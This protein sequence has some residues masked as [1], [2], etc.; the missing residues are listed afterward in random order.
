MSTWTATIISLT[1]TGT[2]TEV[3]VVLFDGGSNKFQQSY[4][5]DGTL[6]SLAPL[7]RQTTA[8][9]DHKAQ[10]SDLVVGALIDLTPP[11][12]VTP[13]PPDPLVVQF[14]IDLQALQQEVR[15]LALGL[16]TGADVTALRAKVQSDL[17]KTPSLGS[18]L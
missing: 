8:Q 9:Q 16:T 14:L 2:G 4:Q 17:G 11:V 7:V 10:K 3:G 12:V 5:T 6:A 13:P 18:L 1:P 15:A